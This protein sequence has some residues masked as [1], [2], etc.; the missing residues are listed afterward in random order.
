[1]SRREDAYA[2]VIRLLEAAEFEA[3]ANWCDLVCQDAARR[4]N[5]TGDI[6]PVDD[7][8][9]GAALLAYSAITD[10]LTIVRRTGA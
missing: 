9:Y 8:E 10:A 5:W 6:G 2:E 1:M 3:G 4:L 7:P